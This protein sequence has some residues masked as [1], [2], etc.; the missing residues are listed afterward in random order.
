M[1]LDRQISEQQE[2]RFRR[3][4]S[5]LCTLKNLLRQGIGIRGGDEA[6]SNIFQFNLDKAR[7]DDNLRVFLKILDEIRENGPFGVIADEATAIS[8]K[9]QMSITLGTCAKDY[10]NSRI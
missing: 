2:Q 5:H 7:T 8:K 10:W 3:L 1:Q 4:I 6:N 9:E